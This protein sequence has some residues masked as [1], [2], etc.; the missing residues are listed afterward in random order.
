MAPPPVPRGPR[1]QPDL[2]ARLLDGYTLDASEMFQL[3][4][5]AAEGRD[6]AYAYPRPDE[7]LA[8]A[9]LPSPLAPIRAPPAQWSVGSDVE[10]LL[11]TLTPGSLRAP[12]LASGH[13]S[14]SGRMSM[15]R[16]TRQELASGLLS[17]PSA[18]GHCSAAAPVGGSSLAVTVSRVDVTAQ[19]S[20]LAVSPRA[21]PLSSRPRNGPFC[22]ACP[23]H[24]IELGWSV[25]GGRR[26]VGNRK[27]GGMRSLRAHPAADSSIVVGEGA[28]GSIL[29]RGI[30]EA[31]MGASVERGMRGVTEGAILGRDEGEGTPIDNLGREAVDEGAEK[32]AA[33]DRP[34]HCR[35]E[36]GWLADGEAAEG[37]HA[38]RGRACGGES[39]AKRRRECGGNTLGGRGYVEVSAEGG[40]AGEPS[41]SGLVHTTG[42]SLSS[43]RRCP[44][45]GNEAL[46]DSP[47]SP[48]IDPLQN[49]VAPALFDCF[50]EKTRSIANARAPSAGAAAKLWKGS[51]PI[52]PNFCPKPSSPEAYHPD[53][54]SAL[55]PSVSASL[56]PP[57]V[58]AVPATVTALFMTP[59]GSS[60]A[61][62]PPVSARADPPAHASSASLSLPPVSPAVAVLLPVLSPA[63]G[64]PVVSSAI[65]VTP[66]VSTLQLLPLSLS[67]HEPAPAS[68][69]RPVPSLVSP[70]GAS[71]AAL[72]SIRM[73]PDAEVLLLSLQTT[74]VSSAVPSSSHSTKP[75]YTALALCS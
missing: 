37:G 38:L 66:P 26:V 6:Y 69:G 36:G 59:S 40:M 24:R 33:T 16:T 17:V 74:Q 18:R 14:G 27:E 25:E 22:E 54:A 58:S 5:N 63:A 2:V 11:N 73:P 12:L 46:P 48:S 42:P 39:A 71:L 9:T 1:P 41:V 44:A 56:T 53:S 29:G 21:L 43:A 75:H 3:K 13:N 52:A 35:D 70:R 50:G 7:L 67:S 60:L 57:S 47:A 31:A 28:V 20:P 49:L 65:A 32:W 64:S 19:R 55:P 4:R 45:G 30:G 51:L 34:T 15:P 10:M 68:S 61:A 62:L 8:R 72:E 23:E